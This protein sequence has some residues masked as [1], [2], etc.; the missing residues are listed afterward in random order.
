M[1]IVIVETLRDDQIQDLWD[2]MEHPERFPEEWRES[3]AHEM[4]KRGLTS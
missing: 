2:A 3:L 1:T 4:E